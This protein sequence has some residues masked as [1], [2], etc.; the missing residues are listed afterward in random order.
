MADSEPL[1]RESLI[2]E[3]LLKHEHLST[4]TFRSQ[5]IAAINRSPP[6]CMVYTWT[7]EKPV[8][9]EEAA[10]LLCQAFASF[11]KSVP[12]LSFLKSSISGNG[13]DCFYAHVEFTSS[14]LHQTE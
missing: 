2:A 4:S 7:S 5:I 13:T 9:S 8:L 12:H 3:A 11:I 14:K 6:N 10:K 1:P